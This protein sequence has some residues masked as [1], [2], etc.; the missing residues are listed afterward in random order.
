MSSNGGGTQGLKLFNRIGGFFR[1]EHWGAGRKDVKISQEPQPI[2]YQEG[3]QPAS[4][5]KAEIPFRV[6]SEKTNPVEGTSMLPPVGERTNKFPADE[7]TSGE[8]KI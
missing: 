5:A 8:K 6:G 1:P 7:V 3:Q 4:E 2:A